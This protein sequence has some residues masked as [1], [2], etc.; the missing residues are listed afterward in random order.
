M[1]SAT[2]VDQ[3]G[4]FGCDTWLD[5]KEDIMLFLLVDGKEVHW[6]RVCVLSLLTMQWSMLSHGN[7]LMVICS[8]FMAVCDHSFWGISGLSFIQLYVV[9]SCLDLISAIYLIPS[10]VYHP[11]WVRHGVSCFRNKTK[12][13]DPVAP[14][15]N[16]TT[17]ASQISSWSH[18]LNHLR[19][20]NDIMN[21]QTLKFVILA[22]IETSLNSI[23]QRH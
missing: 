10:H 4:L 16:N 17:I 15:S 13:W 2:I 21:L 11:G 18:W 7:C 1:H 12:N 19:Y 5:S 6:G 14:D 23:S 22:A 3:I 20:L 8:S 9:S